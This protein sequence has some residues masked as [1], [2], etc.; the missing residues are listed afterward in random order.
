MFGISHTANTL[1]GDPM[2]VGIS[3]GEKKRT[4]LAET[5]IARATVA[6]FDNSTRGL[7]SSTALDFVKSLRVL[8]DVAKLTAIVSLYQAGEGIYEL[9]DKVML[10]DAGLCIVRLCSLMHWVDSDHSL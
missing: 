3:G 10:I 7:D 9:F 2:T 8:T 4:S 5:L 6:A 1:V